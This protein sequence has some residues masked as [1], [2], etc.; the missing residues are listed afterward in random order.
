VAGTPAAI[1]RTIIRNGSG[2]STSTSGFTVGDFKKVIDLAPFTKT[3]A[4]TAVKLSFVANVTTQG[5]AGA[6]CLWQLRVDGVNSQGGTLQSDGTALPSAATVTV[7]ISLG[8]VFEGLTAATHTLS[9]WVESN[10]AGATCSQ[11]GGGYVES[12]VVEEVS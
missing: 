11:N 5:V 8:G 6:T 9:L 2:W 10:S 12:I 3:L 4:S 7:P 1:K